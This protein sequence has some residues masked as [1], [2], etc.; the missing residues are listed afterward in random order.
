MNSLKP[1]AL[2]SRLPSLDELIGC[3]GLPVDFTGM[4]ADRDSLKPL[5]AQDGDIDRV[6]TVGQLN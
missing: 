4:D 2:S 3:Q 1:T 6:D 5:L